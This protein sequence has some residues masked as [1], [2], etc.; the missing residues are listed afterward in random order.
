MSDSSQ[1]QQIPNTIIDLLVNDLFKKNGISLDSAK[2][3]LSDEQK[4]KLKELVNDLTQQVN[5]FVNTQ[6]TDNKERS[7]K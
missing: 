6:T 2:G 7:E 3:K 4:H 1:N 5:T